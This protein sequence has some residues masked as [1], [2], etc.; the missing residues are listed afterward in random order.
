MEQQWFSSS[1]NHKK[2]FL[3]FHKI[4]SQSYK[5]ELS[6]K[7]YEGCLLTVATTVTF[8]VTNAKIYVQLLLY[9]QKTI[10]N[11]QN[12]L[13]KDLKDQFIGINIR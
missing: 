13:A 2:P 10:Q 9:Q 12:Y 6:L 7:W 11:Y 1:R 5:I 3:I 4:L 8:K